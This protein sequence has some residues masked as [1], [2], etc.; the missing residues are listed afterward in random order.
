MGLSDV[1]NSPTLSHQDTWLLELEERQR[2]KN[3][4][5]L[6]ETLQTSSSDKDPLTN[7]RRGSHSPQM[8]RENCKQDPD[9][10]NLLPIHRAVSQQES[11]SI[12]PNLKPDY[13]RRQSVSPRRQSSSGS[14]KLYPSTR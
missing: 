13:L 1:P 5:S 9:Y 3:G 12:C 6:A 7:R 2:Q 14:T 4:E 10:F 8:Q 11:Q